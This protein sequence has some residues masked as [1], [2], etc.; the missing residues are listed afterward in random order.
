MC[1]YVY[2]VQRPYGDNTTGPEYDLLMF[3]FKNH[4]E[5]EDLIMMRISELYFM[6]AGSC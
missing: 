1:L 2:D 5:G 4:Y 6:V 3:H